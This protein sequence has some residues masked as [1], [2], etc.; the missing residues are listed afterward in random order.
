[1]GGQ[2]CIRLLERLDVPAARSR[3]STRATL[4]PREAASRA[5]PAPVTPPPTTSTSNCSSRNRRRSATRRIGESRPA[6]F[7]ETEGERTRPTLS[8][9]GV[10]HAGENA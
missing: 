6:A 9:P 4:R 3:A 2:R 5:A 1:Y 7:R 10:T 8:L